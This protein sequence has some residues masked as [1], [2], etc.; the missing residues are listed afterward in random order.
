MKI[1]GDGALI[2]QYF[3]HQNVDG[4]VYLAMINQRV[5]PS[6]EERHHFQRQTD[7]SG[8]CGRHKTVPLPS[9][10]D[11]EGS[12]VRVVRRQNHSVRRTCGMAPK[13]SRLITNGLLR[14]GYLKSKVYSSPPAD[15]DDLQQRI[16]SEANSLREDRQTHTH[17]EKRTPCGKLKARSYVQVP[18]ITMK[19]DI[20]MKIIDCCDFWLFIYSFSLFF[21]FSCFICLD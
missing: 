16:V 14:L 6:L 21:W 15:L 19:K 17:R 4:E 10:T 11:R 20:S 2:G 7:N 12:T 1:I 18:I 3:F 8:I 5:V 13:I 9:K